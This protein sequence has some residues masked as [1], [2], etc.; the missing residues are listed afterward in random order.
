MRIAIIQTPGSNCDQ[1]AFHA[2]NDRLGFAANYVWHK[3]T[4]LQ[5]FDAV[6]VPGGFTYGDYLRGGAIAS[7]SPIVSEVVRFANEGRPVIGICNGFQI[8][9]EA[10]VLPGAL[11]RN[12]GMK[13]IC[14]KVYIKPVNKT[15]LWTSG[16]DNVLRVP[17]AHNEGR[18]IADDETVAMLR[19]EDRIAFAYC[20]SDGQVSGE[21]NPNGAMENIAGI[22]NEKGN[23]LGMMPHPERACAQILGGIDGKSILSKLAG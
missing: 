7:R 11:V 3:E 13:F 21:Y 19:D 4:S 12:A 2:L 23:V 5:G 20:G 18:Y 16:I 10:G 22:L 8:L 14:K 17:I 15:S 6:V 9:T 1:D